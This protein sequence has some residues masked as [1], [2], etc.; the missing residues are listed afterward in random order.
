MANALEP[1]GLIFYTIWE[2][3]Y[4]ILIPRGYKMLYQ[5]SLKI[6]P[7]SAACWF[8]H[9]L[10]CLNVGDFKS[11]IRSFIIGL[12]IEP[13]NDDALCNYGLALVDASSD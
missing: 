13:P 4:P 8:N 6:D 2:I 5:Q 12:K 7:F 11:A 10:A 9:G 3:Y 1:G